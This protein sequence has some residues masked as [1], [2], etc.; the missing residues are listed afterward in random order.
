MK[1]V[2]LFKMIEME[3]SSLIKDQIVKENL[4]AF[5]DTL[6]SIYEDCYGS[7]KYFIKKGE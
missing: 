7:Q 4:D 3:G 2:E 6:K 1:I 5:K